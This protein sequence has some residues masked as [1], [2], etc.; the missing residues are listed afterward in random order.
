MNN[1]K[2][3]NK[4]LPPRVFT[5]SSN[6]ILFNNQNKNKIFFKD[7]ENSEWINNQNLDLSPF[8]SLNTKIIDSKNENN[9]NEEINLKDRIQSDEV[10]NYIIKELCLDEYMTKFNEINMKLNDFLLLNEN[11]MRNLNFNFIETN[12]V[13]YFIQKYTPFSKKRTMS[14]AMYFF[15][16]Y[17]FIGRSRKLES[18][19]EKEEKNED[20]EKYN[21]IFN[22]G[23][24]NIYN[25]EDVNI[26]GIKIENDKKVSN[27]TISGDEKEKEKSKGNQ[28]ENKEEIMK[29]KNDGKCRS[30]RKRNVYYE[31][32]N[33]INERQ[34][35]KINGNLNFD[36]VNKNID[37]IISDIRRL[38]KGINNHKLCIVNKV[39]KEKNRDIS[40]IY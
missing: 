30:N 39:I 22:C 33:K 19:Y 27:N 28:N 21:K 31:E 16:L 32:K 20:K 3:I 12:R 34:T 29:S 2:I 4:T 7:E 11:D 17:P 14:E 5:I 25:Y 13:K 15:K 38:K 18:E 8:T 10:F 23:F 40:Y 6:L 36:L 1:K 37:T 35:Q 24:N 26:S 9:N